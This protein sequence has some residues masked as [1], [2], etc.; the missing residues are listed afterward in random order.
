[1]FT[2][3][4]DTHTSL[5][6]TMVAPESKAAT[7]GEAHAHTASEWYFGL[8]YRV[9]G[10]SRVPSPLFDENFT[11]QAFSDEVGVST[12]DKDFYRVFSAYMI[13]WYRTWHTAE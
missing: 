1:M 7:M 12:E 10:Y 3:E 6:E 4:C 8:D 9:R 5:S 2:D 11:P 13:A